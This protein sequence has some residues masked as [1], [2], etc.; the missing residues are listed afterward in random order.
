[1]ERVQLSDISM[2]Y[3]NMTDPVVGGYTPEKVALR[4][5]I[6][7]AYNTDEEVR[8]P[9]R[10]QA[11]VA[12][13]VIQ[14]NTGSYDPKIRTEMGVFDRAKASALL[15]MYGYTDKNGDGWRDMPDG[16]PLVLELNTLGTA[17]YREL[18]EIIKKNMDAIGVKF[19]FRIGQWP[20]QLKAARAAKMQMWQVGL[21]AAQPDSSPALQLGYTKQWGQQNLARFSNK[22]F[23]EL[24]EKQ[25]VMPDGP[26][27]DA[28]I[29]EAAR[30]MVAYM[31]YKVRVHRIGTDLWQEWLAGYKR[32]PFSLSFWRYVDIDTSKLPQ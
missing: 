12:Q 16:S 24:F 11:I 27:R 26:E 22:R 18:D 23:D 20:E 32:H 1:M 9:R 19:N 21:Q 25:G 4:R 31:P 2:M 13:S 7:L 3:F 15:D 6:A 5:A 17:D 30:I 28:T 14:P 8:L 29:R 10:G